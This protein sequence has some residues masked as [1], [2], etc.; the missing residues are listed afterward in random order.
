MIFFKT[1]F[2]ITASADG[3]V[4][5]WKKGDDGI[6]FVKHF[7]THLGKKCFYSVVVA[8]KKLKIAE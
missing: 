5:F 4:K 3:H 6:E 1:D 7:R 8:L 2:V